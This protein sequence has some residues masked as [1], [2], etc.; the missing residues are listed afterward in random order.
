M[1]GNVIIRLRGMSRSRISRCSSTALITSVRP[2][3]YNQSGRNRLQQVA[4]QSDDASSAELHDLQAWMRCIIISKKNIHFIFAFVSG[5]IYLNI[6]GNGR[7]R[8]RARDQSLI[9]AYCVRTRT[10]TSF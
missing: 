2:F 7:A 9:Q 10:R 1:F 5:F 3:A 6:D 4:I 8:E